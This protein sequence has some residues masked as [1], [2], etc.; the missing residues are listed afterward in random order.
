MQCI[1]MPYTS[2]IFI[3]KCFFLANAIIQRLGRAS[4]KRKKY[5]IFLEKAM[6]VVCNDC[7]HLSDDNLL[8]IPVS[9]IKMKIKLINC[10]GSNEDY[11]HIVD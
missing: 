5:F 7:T 9:A 6:H 4:I 10:F 3:I 1:R 8:S 2:N 11:P